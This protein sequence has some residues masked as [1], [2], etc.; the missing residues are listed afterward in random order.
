MRKPSLEDLLEHIDNPARVAVVFF[1]D[2]F[3][4]TECELHAMGEEIEA[5]ATESIGPS[6][7]RHPH[8]SYLLF[9][10]LMQKY[11]DSWCSSQNEYKKEYYENLR[12]ESC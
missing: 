10:K 6:I 7:K 4:K 5:L 3:G 8:L 12:N 9:S 11:Y 2:D 1:D